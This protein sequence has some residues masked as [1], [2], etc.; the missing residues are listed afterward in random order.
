MNDLDI[1]DLELIDLLKHNPEKG[2]AAA[3]EQYSGL[4]KSVVIRLL[5]SQNQRDI[6]ECVADV[7]V[8]LYENIDKFKA[9]AGSI[10]GYICGIARHTALDYRRRLQR[11]NSYLTDAENDLGV[12]FD[13][14]DKMVQKINGE[15]LRETIAALP[16]P[17]R[18]IFIL[19]YYFGEKIADIAARLEL[20]PKTVENKLYRGRQKLKQD[21]VNRGIVL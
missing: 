6:E 1:N 19:R 3:I 8:K 20:S 17:D 15:I 11:H 9:E 12:D 21:L 2:L 5:G 16:Y 7:F 4:V 10:R 13:P 14:T 18:E